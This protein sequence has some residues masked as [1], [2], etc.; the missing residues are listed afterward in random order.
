MKA[1]TFLLVCVF[2]AALFAFDGAR[3]L[4]VTAD[5]FETSIRPLAEW[6]HASGVPTHV[7][8]L[9]ETGSSI[10]DIQD[11]IENAYDNWP[12]QP[13]F[14][15]LVGHPYYL[16]AA[17]YGQGGWRYY[18]DNYYA[19]MSGDLR[20]ELKVGRF[21]VRTTG[22]CDVMVAKT[23]AY[24][25]TPDMSDSLWM[26]RLTVIARE[27]YD[28]PDDSIYW[29]NVRYMASLAGAAGFVGC[30]SFSRARGHTAWHVENSVSNGTGFVMFRGSG[31]GNWGDPFGVNPAA[32]SNGEQL[33]V[34]LSV[35]CATMS[36]NPYD[37][38]VG[39]AWVK[40]G[41]VGDPRGGVAFFGNTHSGMRIAQVR[42]SVARGFATGLFLDER[43][44]L[45]D[46]MLRAKQQLY[47]EFPQESEDYRGFSLFGDPE[48]KMWTATPRMLDVDHPAE[49][50]PEP[51][52]IEVNVTHNGMPIANALVCLSMDST[53]YAYQHTNGS[54]NVTLDVSPS[55]TGWMRI[56]VTGRNCHPYD[57][58]I[59]VVTQVGISEN[60][61]AG[62][63]GTGFAIRAWPS[64]FDG[65]TMLSFSQPLTAGSEVLV[66]DA[67]GRRVRVLH[68]DG[69]GS[70]RW[71]GRDAAGT[72]VRAGVYFCDVP[73]TATRA[74]LTKTD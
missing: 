40:A 57:S 61:P 8:K 34:I 15:L 64:V 10:Q 55:D 4:I 67:A 60:P 37:S 47:D 38:M 5:Q 21:P 9:S 29:Q 53:V 27:D 62:L 35:T 20:A 58:L 24:E 41:T 74:R 45:G 23:L 73:G 49:V 25:R 17:R 6:K 59:H 46:A 36:L 44:Q 12:I 69:S 30:D 65:S 26:R 19:D 7:V 33:P 22:Q 52:S 32:C 71:D 11:Y 16:P 1:R 14:V 63:P 39:S 54:G 48:L 42:S 66:R 31:T 68:A 3:Y 72:P 28:P 2:A 13:E 70:V 18:S 43:F 51:Q 56:V 50:L